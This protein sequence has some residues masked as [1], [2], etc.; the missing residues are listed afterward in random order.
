M[1]TDRVKCRACGAALT[2]PFLDL[3]PTPLA[4][5][6]LR[7]EDLNRP[8][9]FYPLPVHVCPGCFL[10]QVPV[11]QSP[12]A[13]FGDYAYFSSYS[14][15][16]LKHAEDYVRLMA[17]RRGLTA[18]SLVIEIASNDGYLLQFF[19]KLGVP[20][21]GI[22]PA[23]NV[24]TAA[25]AAGIPTLIEF[26][27]STL[28][29]RLVAEDKQAD[30]IVG[31]NVLA[32][33]PDLNGFVG[34]LKIALKPGGLITL[35]FPH[36]LRLMA[37]TQFD[38][39]YHEHLSYFSLA[40]VSRVFASHGLTVVDVDELSTHGG[41]LRVHACHDGDAGA[42]PRD[43][44]RALIAREEDFGLA[45]LDRYRAFAAQVQETKR[46]LLDFLVAT[47]R[48][49]ASIVGYGAP[50]KGN[51]LLNYCGVRTDF[52]DYTVDRSPHKQ[53]HFL[54]GTRIPI[55]APAKIMETRPD[56]VLILPW[57]LKAEIMKE[58]ADI[59]TWH[60]RFVTP[61]PRVEIHE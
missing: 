15:S 43:R 7:P 2:D 50:A 59:R 9:P 30:L 56:Y 45:G 46:D 20:V 4:N 14:S 29:R 52:L 26:F 19:Q 17:A 47:K 42:Y 6:Y 8:E 22:E 31:N 33:V 21:L 39:I 38:T 1:T 60:G 54:P 49:G 5:S 61:V 37:E 13:I 44:V 3:G 57:N 36:L 11:V 18:R 16:W 48:K 58:M 34:G 40:V 51:T 28:A 10:V 24:A 23:R 32:H 41:S 53:G 12:G 35:E 27:D 25:Q 55:H